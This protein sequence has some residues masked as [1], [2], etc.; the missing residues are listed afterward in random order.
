MFPEQKYFKTVILSQSKDPEDASFTTPM[1]GVLSMLLRENALTLHSSSKHSRDPSTPRQPEACR[2]NSRGASLRITVRK[3]VIRRV[4][5]DRSYLSI[6]NT[7]C[8]LALMV[9]F[10]GRTGGG[11]GEAPSS[12]PRRR[13]GASRCDQTPRALAKSL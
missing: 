4:Q 12:W 11:G 10:S 5:L 3:I 13:W 1:Q 9:I 2:P 7:H 6:P 8:T